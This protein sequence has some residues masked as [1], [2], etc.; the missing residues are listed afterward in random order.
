MSGAK[1]IQKMMEFELDNCKKNISFYEDQIKKNEKQG[2]FYTE[3]ITVMQ[4]KIEELENNLNTAMSVL[5]A[6]EEP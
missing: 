5:T 4:R 2:D 6:P 3:Q 1:K